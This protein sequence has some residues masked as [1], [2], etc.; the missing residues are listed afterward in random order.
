MKSFILLGSVLMGIAIIIGAFGAHAIKTKVLP[1]D[2][3]IFETGIKYHFYHS[4]GLIITVS[5]THLTLPTIY[6]V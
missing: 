6:S 4:L 3:A 5:Y 2:L 1:E